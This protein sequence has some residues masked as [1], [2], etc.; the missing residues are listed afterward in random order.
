MKTLVW[1][2][3]DLRLADHPPLAEAAGGAMLALFVAEPSVME[4]EDFAP[5][6]RRFVWQSLAGLREALA[7]RGGRLAF[8]RGEAV[9]VLDRLHAEW[10]FERIVSHQETGNAATYARDRAVAAWCRKRGVEWREHR[11]HGVFRG[12]GDRDGWS[13]RWRRQMKQPT[14]AT[15]TRFQS[16]SIALSV[17]T[18]LPRAEPGVAWLP[19][20][21]A[22]GR[23]TLESFLRERGEEYATRM[24]S[25]VTAPEACS[26]LSPYLAWG[27]VSMR[28]VVQATEARAEALR[29]ARPGTTPWPRS[30][31]AFGKRL[32]WHC[33]FIQKL[34]D[35]PSIEFENMQRACDGLREDEFDEAR[36]E[37][38]KAGRTGY[39][40]VDA[41]MRALREEKWINFRM[42]AMLVSF[43]SHHL[44]LDWRP[45]SRWLARQF[46]DYEPGIH[47]TQFQMQSGV[48][49]INALRIYS[50]AKQVLDHDPDGA[51][52][53]RWCPE[54]APLTGAALANPERLDL[55]AQR[56]LGVRIGRDYPKPLVDHATAVRHARHRIAA[57][58]RTAEAREESRAVYRRHGSRKRPPARRR[59]GA[60][61]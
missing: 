61:R 25:P 53:H 14:V 18:E 49:G 42:R 38:W 60:G 48:T 15:P 29:A 35:Q 30:L 44:W 12:L 55:D 58:R 56:R 1:L 46:L 23:E 32:R 34:E 26:R 51:F 27:N 17:E 57:V 2:K 52:I 19:G 3:R 24:S 33:H 37:A 41:C 13:A 54:L 22:A 6:H 45:T 5:C 40:M 4:A 21:E 31:A 9:D 43:A 47:Y 39:P 59:Q 8:A 20:G 28:A 50:P 10:P 11:Q 36:F 16:P 7:A